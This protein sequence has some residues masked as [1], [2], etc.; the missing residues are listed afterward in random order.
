MAP[1]TVRYLAAKRSVDDR[2]LSRRVRDHLCAALPTAP[3]V[4]EA[5]CGTGV[6]VPR[7]LE[8]G[9]TA[10]SYIG[11]D[12]TRETI[13]HARAVRPAELR[14][15][16]YD[17]TETDSELR[18][19]GLSV[20]FETGDALVRA[21]E[22][23]PHDLIV[24]QQFVDIVD[25]DRAVEVFTEALRPGGLAYFPL[26][27][28]GVSLFEPPHTADGEMLTAYH[29][30]MDERTG[31]SRA[32]RELLDSLQLRPGTVL[33]VDSA[34]A[35]VRP[36][37][38]GYPADERFFLDS[39]LSFID[40]AVTPTDVP[41]RDDWLRTRRQQVRDAELLYVGH[42]YDILYETISG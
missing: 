31:S 19:E 13:E 39:I 16:D 8:W 25:I 36:R 7:L 11:V 20:S 4:F 9:L 35:I 27:F 21:G 33:A 32:G 18:A 23:A 1:S 12:T 26:T 17:V 3:A 10:G 15:M 42:R 37:N 5:G 40:D 14:R 6:T 22:T 2:S 30:T 24:A 28:D 34:D 41:A 38:G 29:A